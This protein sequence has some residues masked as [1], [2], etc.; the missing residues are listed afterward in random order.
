MSS[1]SW[2]HSRVHRQTFE[3]TY[4][5]HRQAE[6]QER[7]SCRQRHRWSRAR[8]LRLAG[9]DRR[10]LAAQ[11]RH[12]GCDESY[13]QAEA[14][15]AGS[16]TKS[17]DGVSGCRKAQERCA[18]FVRPATCQAYYLARAHRGRLH[19]RREARKYLGW[20]RRTLS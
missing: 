12:Y 17:E 20:F 6:R 15:R 1:S 18:I 9:K 7:L 19:Q 3:Q 2:R 13:V 4:R 14:Q 8:I 16:S 5:R 11:N 10:Y